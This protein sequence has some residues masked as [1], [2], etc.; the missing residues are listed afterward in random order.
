LFEFCCHRILEAENGIANSVS[1]NPSR[2]EEDEEEE[3][4]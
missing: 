4:E 1:A 3:E 2:E